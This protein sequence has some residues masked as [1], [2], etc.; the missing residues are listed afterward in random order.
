MIELGGFRVETLRPSGVLVGFRPFEVHPRE[1]HRDLWKTR[2]MA[3]T[4]RTS[5]GQPKEPEQHGDPAPQKGRRS[6]PRRIQLTGVVLWLLGM[7]SGV[8][9][10]GQI[11]ILLVVVGTVGRTRNKAAI[12]RFRREQQ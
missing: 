3:G 6:V 4:G 5:A 8:P 1:V 2:V 11:G 10:V 12:R 7:I 9:V